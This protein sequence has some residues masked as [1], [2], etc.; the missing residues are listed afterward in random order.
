MCISWKYLMYLLCYGAA[1]VLFSYLLYFFL[2]VTD[3]SCMLVQLILLLIN[4]PLLLTAWISSRDQH[5][6]YLYLPPLLISQLYL[7][8]QGEMKFI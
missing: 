4:T 5:S 8:W 3:F 6:W 2:A 7:W 1:A